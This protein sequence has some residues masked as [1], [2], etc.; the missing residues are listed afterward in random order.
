[1]LADEVD[2]GVVQVATAAERDRLRAAPAHGA[3]RRRGVEHEDVLVA[4][5][6]RRGAAGGAVRADPQRPLAVV[7]PHRRAR[8]VEAD[9]RLLRLRL[10]RRRGCGRGRRRA[11]AAGCGSSS[12]GSSAAAAAAAPAAALDFRRARFDS[13]GMFLSVGFKVLCVLVH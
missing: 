12:D 9:G 7:Q 8:E 13:G 4:Q 11:A 5:Q 3:R 10:G 2:D 1:V 6:L